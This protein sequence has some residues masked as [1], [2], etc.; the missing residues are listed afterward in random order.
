MNLQNIQ[1]SFQDTFFIEKGHKYINIKTKK[2]LISVT[3]ALKKYQQPFDEDYWSKY[4]AK[5]YGVSQEVVLQNWKMKNDIGLFLGSLIHNYIEAYQYRK[6]IDFT[7]PPSLDYLNASQRIILERYKNNLKLQAERFIKD[8]KSRKLIQPELVVGNDVIAG[9]IDYPTTT[10][11]L[12]FKGLALDTVIATPE[13]F[14]R[15][16][17]IKKGDLIFNGSGEITKVK[18]ISDIHYNP[19][20]ELTFH[21]NEKIVADHEHRWI[22]N[23]GIRGRNLKEKIYTTEQ[24]AAHIGIYGTT[25]KLSINNNSKLDLPD[26][27]LPIDPYVLGLWLAN[28]NSHCGTIMSTLDITWDEIKKRG[29]DISHNLEKDPSRP[30][31]KTVYGLY[32]QLRLLNLLKNKHVPLNYMRA[33]YNQRLDLLRGYMDGDGHYHKKRNRCVMITTNNRQA[34]DIRD[35]V[36]TLGSTATIVNAKT[37]GFG[38]KNIKTWHTTF[39]PPF[40]PFL[41]RNN[42]YDLNNKRVRDHYRYIKSIKKIE[43]V[44]TKCISVES[45]CKSYLAGPTLIK[46]HNTDTGI[47][48]HNKYQN[49]KYPLNHLSDCNYNKYC[50]QV[51]M[52]RYLLEEAG[53]IL[54]ELDKIIK[55]DR[56]TTKYQIYEIPYLK[57]ECEL[58][59]K[60]IKNDN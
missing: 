13:G 10:C 42:N 33:S 50:L 6:L 37:S 55:F 48:F 23:K 29:Y 53:M 41:L 5:E 52:Y 60:N 46:T 38:K 9:Q 34:L 3:T 25:N 21:T 43:T 28:G 27:E 57:D 24:I 51:S 30:C 58:I 15:M 19:C 39:S 59:I 7:T 16:E 4:K 56:Y 8:F 54:L 35:L 45:K 14:I 12:D 36:A 32:K 2:E 17:N 1:K 26:K 11:I 20:Y 44:A 18:D 22:I 31:Y 49:M 47:K 40:N